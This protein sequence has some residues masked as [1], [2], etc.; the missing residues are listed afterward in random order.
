MESIG[1]YLQQVPARF[2][3]SRL[4]SAVRPAFRR[5]GQNLY[6]FVLGSLGLLLSSA[7]VNAEVVRY[8]YV[9]DFG[10]NAVSVFRI[11]PN[12]GALTMASV[13]ATGNG[14]FSVGVDPAG[15]FAFVSN[16]AETSGTPSISVFAIDQN[17]GALTEVPG[18]P[19][20]TAVGSPQGLTVHP[21]GRF[22][23]VAHDLSASFVSAYSIN[24]QTG[25][26]SPL[27]GSP[28]STGGVNTWS[29]S[30]DPAGKFLFVANGTSGNIP[31]FTIDPNTGALAPVPGSPFASQ[32]DVDKTVVDPSGRFLYA[33]N[34]AFNSVSGYAIS[35]TS[36]ALTPVAGSPF[37]TG[38]TPLGVVT[39]TTGRFL[40]VTNLNSASV[41][42]FGIDSTSGSLT[43]L[44]GST[45][46]V[47][48]LPYHATVDPTGS[49]LYVT[50]FGSNN[51]TAYA[52]NA[53]TGGLT[54]VAGS[55]FTTGTAP[56]WIAIASVTPSSQ[57]TIRPNSGGNTGNVT[58]QL[59]GGGAQAGATVKLTGLGPDIIG[60]TVPSALVLTTTFIL[61]GATPG[62]RD[63]AVTNLDGTSATLPAGFTVKQ[64]GA[65]QISEDIIGRNQIR[66]GRDQTY[67]LILSNQGNVDSDLGI[68]EI[69]VPVGA[70][71]RLSSPA[72]PPPA[73]GQTLL[74]LSDISDSYEVTNGG[75]LNVPLLSISPASS[76]SAF[77]STISTAVNA[78]LMTCGVVRPP[79]SCPARLQCWADILAFY[80]GQPGIVPP[81]YNQALG[82]ALTAYKSYCRTLELAASGGQ[83]AWP[84]TRVV[85]GPL[86][87]CLLPFATD[88]ND[89]KRIAYPLINRSLAVIG[90]FPSCKDVWVP[91]V[92]KCLFVQP[93]ASLDPNDKVGLTGSGASRFVSGRSPNTYSIYFDNQPTAT[94][95]TQSVTVTD[96]IDPSLD[97]ATVTLGL[98]T[99][100]NQ[101]IS[102]PPVPLSVA[103]F[104]TTVDLRPGNQLLLKISASLN[105][106]TGS[107]SWNFQSLDPNTG[108]PPTDPT[109]GF[110]QAGGEGSVFFT[111]LPKPEVTTG[112]VV[113][114]TATVVFD[115]NPPINTPTWTNTIDSTAPVSTVATLPSIANSLSFPLQWVGTDVG[116][117]IQDFTIY[118]SD[119]GGPFTAFQTNT[120]TTSATFTGQVG[121]TYGFYSIARDLVGNVEAAKTTAESTTLVSGT[122]PAITSANSVT[123]TFGTPGSFTVMATGSPTPT[124][125]ATGVPSGVALVDNGNGTA[126]LS[127][128]TAAAGTYL[129]TI[130]ASNVVGPP[131]T[132]SFTLTVNRATTATTVTVSPGT[133]EYSD[134]TTLAAAVSPASAGGQALT[135]SVQFF[136][137]GSAVGSPVVINSSGGATLSQLQVNLSAA[138]YPV[139]AV[140]SSTNQ[141]F[142]GSTG[143]TTQN[144]AQENAFILYSGD[145]IAQVGTSLNLRA[146]VWDSAATGYP[147][148]NAETG[149]TATIGDITKMWIAFDIYPAGSCGSGTASTLYVQVAST[150][151]PGVGAATSTL[152][153]NSEVSY[154][155]V[156]RLVEGSSGGTNLF[157][158]APDAQ[159]VGVDFYV[160]SGQ[161][162]T[163]GGWVNDAT[164]SHGN[165]G[166]NARYNSA[167]S[168]KGQM[169]YIYRALYN[170]VMADFI[171]K[172]NALNA[173]QFSGT[174]YPI[175]STLQGKVNVQINRASDGLSLFSAGNYTFSAT[176]TD[177]GQNG[178]T[179]K[180]FSLTVYASNGV[181]YHQVAPNTP[182][183]GGN[184]VVHSQ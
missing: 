80:F 91:A 44:S 55:P 177:S 180:Q 67:Y 149:P 114:N 142:A 166:F 41:S 165:F 167:G 143:T 79:S 46:P 18:S 179:G 47:G 115:V 31:V 86:V 26:L 82:C 162:A 58:V 97:L 83:S 39:D 8:A 102:P 176:I 152:S 87:S 33:D 32:H 7:A 10:S 138:S 145:T 59:F 95:S 85:A 160:N 124:M 112:T 14:P 57:L 51:V 107:L 134:Y 15:R 21:S 81:P 29:V 89:A 75:T 9:T 3:S 154:C 69:S 68:S 61:T 175:S 110:L 172:S 60:A 53:T 104:V 129:I 45:F 22:L 24:A 163:G 2:S 131:A 136:L 147:G 133:V 117:G 148:G 66:I 42:A 72:T 118:V 101:I 64:G 56:F 113:Q 125:S 140:F 38:A 37:A 120:T 88:L 156:S 52:I 109:A 19:F 5:K 105:T 111:V 164:G 90:D 99:L 119:N 98:I 158:T 170:G 108:L 169:V 93:A 183:Q 43:A 13:A 116:S 1:F 178:A 100:P 20:P 181:P 151:T 161:F 49:F 94:A 146:T 155:V 35:S 173:L 11:D 16:S 184:V 121:H 122:P 71:V 78:G 27:P 103:P 174:T 130:S 12:S 36:G 153:S 159:P 106:T 62:A 157:Y 70:S 77:G 137:N 48:S 50:N 4:S 132:Q 168:P 127:E 96:K 73:P 23:Y 128:A 84:W 40:Y 135:G 65:P 171:I 54:P 150:S 144:V 141:N 126:T 76:V 74:D 25:A 30:T 34:S 182:L 28:Y 6:T 63:V 17:T 92:Q 123:F 139:K